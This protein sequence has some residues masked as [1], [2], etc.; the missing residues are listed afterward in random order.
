MRRSL[1]AVGVGMV[2]V[3]VGVGVG[4]CATNEPAAVLA[5]GRPAPARA[6]GA[7]PVAAEASASERAIA[8]SAAPAAADVIARVGTQTITKDEILAPMLEEFGLSYLLH[9]VQL[10][11]ARQA[12]A[13]QKV[14]VTEDDVKA[15]RERTFNE[16]LAETRAKLQEQLDEAVAKK[17]NAA[18]E[19]IKAQMKI[20][21]EAALDAYLAQRYAVTREYVSKGEFNIVLETNAY[22]RKIAEASPDLKK[23][24]TDDAVRKAFGAQFGEKVVIRHIQANNLQTI[25]EARRR[26]DAGENFADVARALSTNRNTAPQGGA[27]PPFTV[28][29]PNVPQVFKDVAFGMNIGELSDT[30]ESDNAFH[31]LK[32]E[33]RIAPKVVKFEDVKDKVRAGLMEQVLQAGVKQLRDKVVRQAIANLRIEHPVLKRQFDERREQQ[34]VR[35]QQQLD[36]QMKRDRAQNAPDAPAAPQPG[37]EPAI[38]PA[39]GGDNAAQPAQPEQP[40]SDAGAVTPDAAVAK[41]KAKATKPAQ[42]PAPAA[43]ADE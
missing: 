18:A 41:P 12:A 2:C 10:D 37:G 30:I 34:R 40:A 19:R 17:D 38:E 21:P 35:N 33:N 24:V 28:N 15:E 3:G 25:T 8:A 42:A 39:P 13:Q 36:E 32:L 22:L 26:L 9:L 4:G 1:G 29:A 6:A 31:I 11:L 20:D 16:M 5:A 27:V 23:L 7:A 14:A 43:P